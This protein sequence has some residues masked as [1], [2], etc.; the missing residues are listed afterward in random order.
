M[1]L[2]KDQWFAKIRT[3]VPE[4]FFEAGY[5]QTADFQGIA[6]V[7]ALLETSVEEFRDETFITKADG[8]YLDMHGAERSVPRLPMEVDHP[9]YDARIRS[10]VNVS[11]RVS[12]K[13]LVDSLLVVG[14]STIVEHAYGSA[15]LNR[16]TYFNRAAVLS[17]IY[18]N[19]FSIVI[20]P[21]IHDPFDFLNRTT[22]A[23]R[24]SFLGTNESSLELFKQIVE[25]VNN[26]KAF[27]VLYRILET[28]A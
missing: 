28:S 9:N 23:N 6:A 20:P 27:G 14:E 12:L 3:W 13:R 2:T 22:F 11:D 15:Y 10:I 7:F 1:A 25:A 4:W 5:F 21:Q 24:E 18:Y 19:A 16:N 17:E 8:A 26:A